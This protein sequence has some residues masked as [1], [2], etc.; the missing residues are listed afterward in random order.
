VARSSGAVA[1]ALD[2]LT[3][4]GHAQLTSDK[5]RRYRHQAATALTPATAGTTT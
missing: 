4:L 5:P 2:R 3:A 1:N